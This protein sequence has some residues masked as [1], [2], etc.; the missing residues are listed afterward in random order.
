VS[1]SAAWKAVR[2]DDL[3]S[4]PF[5]G[6]LW[7]PIRRSL[8]VTA[9]GV[10]AYTAEA[11]GGQVIEEHIE[12]G[13][14]QEELYLVLRGRATFTVDGQIC[15]APVGTIIFVRDP[16]LERAAVSEE[17]GTLVLVIGGIPERPYTI[18][19]WEY[20]PDAVPLLK[21]G[22]WDEAIAA[23]EHTLSQRP[24]DPLVLYG[25]ACAES[26]AGRTTEAL[27]HLNSAIRIDATYAQRARMDPHL[28][29]IRKTLDSP[30]L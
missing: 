4:L 5:A 14:G 21:A 17:E 3:E 22:H 9:F 24:D 23:I 26:R 12:S 7:R 29:P 13:S 8:N 6:V 19:P 25:L 30:A 27:A 1:D 18:S 2:L 20:C 28:E 10:N 16:T 11:M 15:D